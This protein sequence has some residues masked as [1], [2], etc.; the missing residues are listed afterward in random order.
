MILKIERYLLQ[1]EC[2]RAARKTAKSREQQKRNVRLALIDWHA[3][4][5]VETIEACW[6]SVWDYL[7]GD[8]S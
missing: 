5:V 6:L 8:V 2:E 7:F 1:A 4:V 3:F